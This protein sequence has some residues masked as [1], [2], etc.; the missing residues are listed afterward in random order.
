MNSDKL[1]RY[2]HFILWTITAALVV[3]LLLIGQWYWAICLPLISII[4]VF[5]WPKKE[6]YY[7]LKKL[8]DDNGLKMSGF[9]S[10][11][12]DLH[13]RPVK[14][15]FAEA[16]HGKGARPEATCFTF[17]IQGT[18]PKKLRMGLQS[19]LHG[20]DISM[21]LQD[22]EVG[23]PHFDNCFLIMGRNEAQIKSYLTPKRQ[24][25]LLQLYNKVSDLDIKKGKL[26]L[27]VEKALSTNPEYFK[28]LF[29]EYSSLV[30]LL[31][32]DDQ[33]EFLHS[34]SPNERISEKRIKRAAKYRLYFGGIILLIIAFLVCLTGI[35][36]Y[37]G[38]GNEY[39][40]FAWKHLHLYFFGSLAVLFIYFLVKDLNNTLKTLLPFKGLFTIVLII[41]TA[42]IAF[43]I[44]ASGFIAH[45]NA[46]FS[47][48]IVGT[49]N[50]RMGLFNIPY[51]HRWNDCKE[52][53][54]F[55]RQFRK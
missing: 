1:F 14:L 27:S 16:T 41:W 6:I 20:F 9:S 36:F 26:I 3:L 31:D 30:P 55:T 46:L 51:C 7:A 15:V 43:F 2:R 32:P 34:H 47:K 48:P 28:L 44:P 39:L 13:G 21:G 35:F 8:A 19:A 18:L 4:T 49:Q 50:I 53:S 17:N 11:K 5:C 25:A 45:L 37:C 12:G 40:T 29:D 23:N 24:Q 38:S 52:L 22:I 42:T 10:I 54:E 33:E